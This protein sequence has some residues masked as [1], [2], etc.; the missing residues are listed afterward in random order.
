M[1]TNLGDVSLGLEVSSKLVLA[2]FLN[3]ERK[4]ERVKKVSEKWNDK[5]EKKDDVPCREPR[6][7]RARNP[8]LPARRD[9]STPA[10]R[11]LEPAPSPCRQRW[12]PGL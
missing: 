5:S 9:G 8:E 4:D 10:E 1:Q 2:E 7:D 3:A 6:P 12:Q 11:L